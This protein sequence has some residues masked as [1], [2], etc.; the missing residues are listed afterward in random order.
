MYTILIVDDEKIERMGVEMLLKRLQLPLKADVAENGETALAM[1][2]HQHYDLLL[3]DIKM[4]FMDGLTLAHKARALHPDLVVL[5]F[6]AYGDFEKA[7]AAIREHVYRYLLKPVNVREFETVMHACKEDLERAKTAVL[8]KSGLEASL[9]GY[10]RRESLLRSQLQDQ[11]AAI[12]REK[13]MEVLADD[14]HGSDPMEGKHEV[15]PTIQRVLEIIRREY[16]DDISVE[17]VAKRICLTPNYLSTLFSRQMNQSYVKYLNN[18]RLDMA[19]HMLTNTNMKI[20]DIAFQVGLPRDSYFVT[21]FKQR[22]G[23][24]PSSFR[25]RS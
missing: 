19:A 7:Q 6:S 18:Y 22:Y 5:I 20:V 3:T 2:G 12:P 17:A 1:I 25:A 11:T 8:E 10:R 21:L 23:V 14:K 13:L 4:P 24:T 16:K 15:N 9:C